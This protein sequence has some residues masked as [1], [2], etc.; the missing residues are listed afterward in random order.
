MK[1]IISLILA[2][3]MIESLAFTSF[4]EEKILSRAS[5]WTITASSSF[6]TGDISAA[7]DGSDASYW[8][9]DYNH[10]GKEFAWIAECPH[11]IHIYF[12][13]ITKVSGFRYLPR[14]DG[15]DVGLFGEFRVFGSKDGTE[16]TEIYEGKFTWDGTDRK[17]KSVSWGDMDL[18]AIQIEILSSNGGFATAAAVDL[19]TGGTGSPLW[20]GVIG[21]PQGRF[22]ESTADF[23]V[24]IFLAGG[25][26]VKALG[27]V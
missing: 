24:Y 2:L 12:G 7:F 1:K 25:E 14:Q 15:N 13:G 6:P 17:A 21:A 18:R 4:A 5:S 19:L 20:F 16:Y 22:S 10:N 11:A 8:H 23:L 3:L 27:G 26:D 9:S